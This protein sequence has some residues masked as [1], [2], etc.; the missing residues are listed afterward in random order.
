[1]TWVESAGTTSPSGAR[2][3]GIQTLALQLGLGHEPQRRGGEGQGRLSRP[4]LLGL[5]CVPSV[6]GLGII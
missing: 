6:L 4:I 3:F 5:E 2:Q 1:M